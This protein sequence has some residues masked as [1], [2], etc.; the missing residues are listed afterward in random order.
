VTNKAGFEPEEF[1]S[2]HLVKFADDVFDGVL[3]AGYYDVLDGV[4]TS[5]C[6]PDNL[7]QDREGSLE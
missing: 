6:G 5:V 3:E 2:I 7:I 1:L 4:Y